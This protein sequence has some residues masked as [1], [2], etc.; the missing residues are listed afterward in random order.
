MPPRP[1]TTA[2]PP[3]M[4]V[5]NRR[6]QRR[7]ALAWAKCGSPWAMAS[8][9]AA[10]NSAAL[11]PWTT[12]VVGDGEAPPGPVEGLHVF[13]SGASE[14]DPRQPWRHGSEF[15][16]GKPPADQDVGIGHAFGKA[17]VVDTPVEADM[18]CEV[19]MTRHRVGHQLLGHVE[20][21][22]LG[23]K[24]ADVNLQGHG[25]STRSRTQLSMAWTSGSRWLNLPGATKGEQRPICWRLETSLSS[26]I[27]RFQRS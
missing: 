23:G 14:R 16:H 18:A 19:R 3:S 8:T 6:D 11:G 9:D 7:C 24:G 26:T 2:V 1:I 22:C 5:V 13:G 12:A 21:A 25:S 27:D 15:A 17:V 10:A 4:R 20:N